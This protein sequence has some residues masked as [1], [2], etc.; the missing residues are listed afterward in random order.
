MICLP[1]TFLPSPGQ[2][3]ILRISAL[4]LL[5]CL[6]IGGTLPAH[7]ASAAVTDAQ[8]SKD[9]NGDLAGRDLSG[10]LLE[11]REFPSADLTNTNFSH[12]KLGGAVFSNGTLKGTNFEGADLTQVLM[13][14]IRL[15]QTNLR[16]TVLTDAI[17]LRTEFR[18][19]DITG[20]DFS[21]ALL[22]GAEMKQLC[23]I[24]T[25]TNSQTG[26]DTRESLGCRG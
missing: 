1:L 4:L 22:S 18:D 16:D 19:V 11:L 12:A 23:K 6:W 5:L 17:L 7:A 24:A 13:D 3:L 20:A 2:R 9:K 10:A 8:I 15:L 21:G 14:Q 26:V 25:G